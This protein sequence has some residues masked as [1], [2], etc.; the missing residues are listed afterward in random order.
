MIDIVLQVA[1]LVFWVACMLALIAGGA[2]WV[3]WRAI[4]APIEQSP[5]QFALVNC[6]RVVAVLVLL[7]LVLSLGLY[8]GVTR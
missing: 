1:A 8:M 7:V 2:A 6:V 5:L 4:H 3:A